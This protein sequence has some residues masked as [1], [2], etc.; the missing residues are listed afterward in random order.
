MNSCINK[1]WFQL[2]P[3]PVSEY[4]ILFISAS[5][6]LP[7]KSTGNTVVEGPPHYTTH[8]T[9]SIKTQST[10]EA[11]TAVMSQLKEKTGDKCLK[12][13]WERIIAATPPLEGAGAP[14]AHSPCLDE[15]TV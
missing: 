3:I 7:I 5:Y 13:V 15:A 1:Y 6:V 8:P 12:R 11:L 14:D 2:T 9:G 4:S 10:K